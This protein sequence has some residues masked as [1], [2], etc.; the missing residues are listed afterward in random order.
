[1]LVLPVIT[2]VG[3]EPK[4]SKLNFK[5]NLESVFMT[6]LTTWKENNLTENLTVRRKLLLAS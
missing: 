1:M 6:D 5:R 3:Q 4:S 2:A